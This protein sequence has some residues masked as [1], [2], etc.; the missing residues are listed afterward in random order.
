MIGIVLL[1]MGGPDS[2]ESVRPFLR[3]LFSDREI[4]QLGPRFMQPVLAALIAWR[5]A[6]KSARAYAE[7]GGK[8]PL[9]KITSEQAKA[10]EYSLKASGLKDVAC[11]P[12]MRYWSPRT[13]QV[14]KRFAESGIRRVVGLTM[15]PHYSKATTGSSVS[16]FLQGC[17]ALGIE[18][19]VIDAYPDH[20]DYIKALL[21]LTSQ[22]ISEIGKKDRKTGYTLVYS[23]H[24]LPK[25]MIDEGDPYLDHLKKTI[26][27][28]E[29]RGGLT[30]TLCFQSRSG[31]V[32]WLR[33]ATDEL[34]M[35]LVS[36][37]MKN[38]VV[39]PISFVSDHIETLYEIDM[40]YG[41]MVSG[42]GS[43]LYRVPAL[44]CHPD[45]INCLKKVTMKKLEE[46]G[47]LRL[48]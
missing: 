25:R 10:L 41:D 16:D 20:P 1:N 38:I 9:L 2:L 35:E 45:F 30:G 4:I 11:A 22:K 31:P 47:W 46:R 12:G 39:L 37:G 24:S 7:I 33:P 27:S 13:P 23:A 29:A 34:L 43:R 14:L 3:N 21:H 19:A 32:E 18:G 6:P 40:L 17:E 26:S 28:L 36:R 48:Q 44:N 42:A 8:S 15:Y 5:R